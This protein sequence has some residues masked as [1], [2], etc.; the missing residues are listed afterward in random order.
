MKEIEFRTLRANEIEVRPQQIKNGTANM[1]L[2]ID[3]RAVVNLL[4]ETVGNMNWQMEFYEV[5]GQTVGRLGIYDEEKNMWIWKSDVGSESN[6][7]A[8]KGL[9][10]D[11]YK[12][13]L[14]RWGICELYSAPK[15]SI[16]DDGH[17]CTGYKVLEI[18]YDNNRNINHLVIGNR[19]GKEVW[20]WD[21][22]KPTQTQTIAYTLRVKPVEEPKAYD[23]D[24]EPQIY[25]DKE[26]E[27]AYD[28]SKKSNREIFTQYCTFLKKEKGT[29]MDELKKFYSYY[30]EKES[31]KMGGIPVDVWERRI[32]PAKLWGSWMARAAS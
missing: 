8:Q 6:V 11:T 7:E 1:L 23:V 16:P 17:K 19:F 26:V 31:K 15:I 10:S 25:N 21:A 30:A 13:T 18:T 12:R 28:Y 4:N 14:S 2:Y 9:I 32:E 3:S 5:N 27:E 29:N 24:V 22:D 20:R